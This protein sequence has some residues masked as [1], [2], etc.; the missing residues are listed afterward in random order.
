[1]FKDNNVLLKIRV[2][3]IETGADFIHAKVP[4][5]H[6]EALRANKNLKVEV[7]GRVYFRR[8]NQIGLPQDA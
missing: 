2:I 5:D 4:V 8:G 3:N 1:M 7:I 6:V